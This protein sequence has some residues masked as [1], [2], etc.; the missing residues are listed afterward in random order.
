LMFECTIVVHKR[1]L[2]CFK[3]TQSMF[4]ATPCSGWNEAIGSFVERSIMKM[5]KNGL[6]VILKTHLCMR[7]V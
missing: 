5:E 4:L 6:K 7:N 2:W 1:G 3:P